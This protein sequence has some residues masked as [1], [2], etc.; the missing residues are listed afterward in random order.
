VKSKKDD[1]RRTRITSRLF[2]V[3]KMPLAATWPIYA[4]SPDSPSLVGSSILFR[5]DDRSCLFTAAHVLHEASEEA[6]HVRL[7]DHAVPLRQSGMFMTSLPGASSDRID[8]GICLLNA[9]EVHSL[10]RNS[11]LE[12]EQV[13]SSLEKKATTVFL[14][15][16]FPV[17][18]QRKRRRAD[19]LHTAA[20][21]HA[22]Q[23]LREDHSE[24]GLDP[25]LHV[26]VEYD[27][28]EAQS[29]SGTIEGPHPRGMSGGGLWYAPNF[30]TD[31][32]S[33][34]IRLAAI[35]VEWD[36]RIDRL[37]A[38]RIQPLFRVL[39]DCWPEKRERF[40]SYFLSG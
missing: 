14:A 23:L 29:S 22:T 18:K 6:L 8:L 40:D 15:V 13:Q 39:G 38:T 36:H 16:G 19:P 4:G 21:I 31:S 32:P 35:I 25:V 37:L 3:G 30:L 1:S 28:D 33:A 5:A 7:G 20:F 24:E 17:S 34:G 2:E 12:L 9:P 26:R 10:P 11:Y 27:R